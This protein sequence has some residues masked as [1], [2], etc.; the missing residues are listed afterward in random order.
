MKSEK[1]LSVDELAEKLGLSKETVYGFNKKGTGPKRIRIGR[2]VR[3]RPAD[4]ESWLES[5]T[6]DP[7]RAA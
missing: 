6:D 7:T 4:V 2:Y 5:L 3:Y 1:L